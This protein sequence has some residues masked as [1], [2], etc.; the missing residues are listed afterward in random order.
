MSCPV[1]SEVFTA[2]KR[3]HVLPCGHTFCTSCLE[4]LH[5]QNSGIIQCPECRGET[6]FETVDKI[7]VNHWAENQSR[8]LQK[9]T[10]SCSLS[11]EQKG[12]Q[13]DLCPVHGR[14]M[15]CWCSTCHISI[16]VDCKQLHVAQKDN[17]YN[18]Q[19]AKDI[20]LS[21]YKNRSWPFLD[22][23]SKV[24]AVTR[25]TLEATEAIVPVLMQTLSVI[26][27]YR[28]Q[29]KEQDQDMNEASSPESMED[30]LEKSTK[31]CKRRKPTA[32][33]QVDKVLVA[34]SKIQPSL[35]DIQKLKTE[36]E[37]KLVEAGEAAAVLSNSESYASSGS[38]EDSSSDLETKEI[39]HSIASITGAL[40]RPLQGCGGDMFIRVPESY[41]ASPCTTHLKLKSE[42]GRPKCGLWFLTYGEK[43]I[44]SIMIRDRYIELHSYSARTG[45]NTTTVQGKGSDCYN[46]EITIIEDNTGYKVKWGELM[47][48]CKKS[49]IG[50]DCSK[51]EVR[52]FSDDELHAL[53]VTKVLTSE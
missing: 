7:P 30:L 14:P 39:L 45:Q 21:Q 52:G 34:F 38:V 29:M 9:E 37:F 50:Y 44:F 18:Y 24:E 13:W 3:P 36:L 28:C 10:S 41:L 47:L 43:T 40:P 20:L 5:Q 8:L 2:E 35:G 12:S 51:I 49:N 23:L 4:K 53:Y 31:W 22:W 17:V 6:L 11:D 1:C 48:E 27:D 15:S 33:Q 26:Q 19:Q 42:S 25:Q 16:C 32:R 46:I